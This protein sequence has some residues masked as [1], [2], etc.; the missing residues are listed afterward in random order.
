MLLRKINF[1]VLPLILI[2]SVSAETIHYSFGHKSYQVTFEPDYLALKSYDI[3]FNL[4]AKDCLKPH[5]QE[6][7]QKIK[8][9]DKD[10]T[11]VPEKKNVTVEVQFKNETFHT[12]QESNLGDQLLRLPSEFIKI[13]IREKE[14]CKK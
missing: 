12:P 6:L 8:N 3:D 9:L 2:S 1:F 10:I 14:L 5:F 7:Y 13:K 11:K 4:S